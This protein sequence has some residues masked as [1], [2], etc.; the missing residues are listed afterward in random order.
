[1]LGWLRAAA[2]RA[3]CSKRRRRSGSALNASGRTL[4]ATSRSSRGS[5]AR[6]TSPIPPLRRGPTTSYGPSRVPACTDTALV[7]RLLSRQRI[8]TN[9]ELDDLALGPFAALDVPDEVRAVVRV[10]RAAFP[11]GI[12]IVDAAV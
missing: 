8:G 7:R 12:G 1:M 5:R 3:S 2:A 9:L 4:M 11:S 6:Y 10:Q